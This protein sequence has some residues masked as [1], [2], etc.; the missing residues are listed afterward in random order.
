MFPGGVKFKTRSMK[1]S[2]CPN[3][4]LALSN[5]I[6]LNQFNVPS[7][8]NYAKLNGKLFSIKY[9][10]LTLIFMLMFPVRL[11]PS[12]PVDFVGLSSVQRGWLQLALNED[13]QFEPFQLSSNDRN[14]FAG[15]IDLEVLLNISKVLLIILRSIF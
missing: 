4:Q 6:I 13:V 12:V 14:S 11:D 3:E 8:T 2:K 7:N 9:K 10:Y 15:R 5:C 1:V